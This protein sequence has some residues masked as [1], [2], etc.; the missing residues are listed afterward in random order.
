MPKRASNSLA[1]ASARDEDCSCRTPVTQ[2]PYPAI[3]RLNYDVP[4]ELERIT[5]K[6]LQK[7]DND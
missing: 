3:A 1:W 2:A 5:L 6:C 4:P 7:H